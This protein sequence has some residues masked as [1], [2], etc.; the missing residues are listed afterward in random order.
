MTEIVQVLGT[1]GVVTVVLGFVKYSLERGNW[2]R[3]KRNADR[4][5]SRQ[6]E[7]KHDDQDL[8]IANDA[9]E[10]TMSYLFEDDVLTVVVER[11]LSDAGFTPLQ[12]QQLLD[13]S[14]LLVRGMAA[15]KFLI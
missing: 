14:L 3:F 4:W 9:D 13:M 15:D 6:V 2:R 1:L 8:S 5:V 12:T 7:L 10:N 11:L